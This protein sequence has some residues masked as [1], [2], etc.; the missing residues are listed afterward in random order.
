MTPP[1]SLSM[2]KMEKNFIAHIEKK[3][4][5][6]PYEEYSIIDCIGFVKREHLELRIAIEAL[7]RSKVAK[8][9][10]IKSDKKGSDL[11]IAAM[12]EVADVSNTLDYLFEGLLRALKT[13]E[14]EI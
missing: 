10:N 5:R 7:E 1:L 3:Y 6:K 9:L 14:G 4:P 2:L 11:I 13:W 8:R 12:W